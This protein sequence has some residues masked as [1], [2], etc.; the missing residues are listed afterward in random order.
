MSDPTATTDH[1][2]VNFNDPTEVL[3]LLG[4]CLAAVPVVLVLGRQYT[5]PLLERAVEWAVTN[6]L[7][8]SAS[9]T[10]LL[11]VPLAGGAGLDLARSIVAVVALLLLVVLLVTVIRTTLRRRRRQQETA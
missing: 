10:P 5:Q 2:P 8:L 11:P 6:D 7:L 1:G 3:T 9:A 4:V